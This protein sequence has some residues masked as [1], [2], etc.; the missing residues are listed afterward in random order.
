MDNKNPGISSPKQMINGT[1]LVLKKESSEL[2][3]KIPFKNRQENGNVIQIIE[4]LFL[5]H[6]RDSAIGIVKCNEI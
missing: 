3:S 5:F 1:L 4:A 6:S 2:N